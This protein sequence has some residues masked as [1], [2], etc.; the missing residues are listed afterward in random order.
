MVGYYNDVRTKSERLP[1]KCL[2]FVNNGRRHVRRQGRGRGRKGQLPP[3]RDR[4]FNEMPGQFAP[5]FW[6]YSNV[7]TYYS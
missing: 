2:K 1:Q 6:S 4:N 7:L 3:P 5:G